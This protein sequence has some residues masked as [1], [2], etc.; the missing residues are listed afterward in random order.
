MDGFLRRNPILRTK[1]AR[2]INSVR[3]NGAITTVI[4]LWFPRF[5]TPTIT[6]IKPENRYN[7]DESGII[8]GYG[9][10]GLVVRSSKTTIYLKETAW[11]TCLNL[12]R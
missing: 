10:N 11:F 9:V 2:T 8:K 5:A 7:M 12:V 6:T 4:R 3:V 1:K